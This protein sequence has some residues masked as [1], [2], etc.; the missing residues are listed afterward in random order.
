MHFSISVRSHTSTHPHI[1]RCIHSFHFSL[2]TANICIAKH[3]AVNLCAVAFTSRANEWVFV[4]E[5][6]YARAL[7]LLCIKCQTLGDRIIYWLVLQLSSSSSSNIDNDYSGSKQEVRATNKVTRRRKNTLTQTVFVQ[8]CSYMFKVMNAQP[9]A[10]VEMQYA[11]GISFFSLFTLDAHRVCVFF[12]VRSFVRFFSLFS[13]CRICS[14][15]ALGTCN[16]KLC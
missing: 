14:S 13:F 7:L 3:I 16:A 11:F 15:A 10:P 8:L 2:C 5:W 12:F 4:R 6:R 1:P 9:Y